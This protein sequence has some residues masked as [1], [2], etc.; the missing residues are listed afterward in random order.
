M[1]GA[2]PHSRWAGIERAAGWLPPWSWTLVWGGAERLEPEL[3]GVGRAKDFGGRRR[4]DRSGDEGGEKYT[5]TT[6]GKVGEE[7]NGVWG[8]GN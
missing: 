5:E 6:E 7:M 8:R 4:V 3:A 1:G 2:V